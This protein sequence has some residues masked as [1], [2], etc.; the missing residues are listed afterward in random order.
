M[1]YSTYSVEKEEKLSLPL[2]S[3]VSLRP[4]F[5]H[6]TVI[7]IILKIFSDQSSKLDTLIFFALFEIGS[8]YVA[9]AS[10][11]LSEIHLPQACATTAAHQQH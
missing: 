5:D 10:G 7:Y 9:Q 8:H 6:E 1:Q 4:S 3:P 2:H 11:E